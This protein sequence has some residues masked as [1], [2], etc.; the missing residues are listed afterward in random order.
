M[1]KIIDFYLNGFSNLPNW[2]RSIWFI[3]LLKLFIFFFI[4]KIFFFQNKLK[5]E[6]NSDEER[7]SHVIEQLT[8]PQK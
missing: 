1:R 5:K 8:N 2:A 7:A 3:V 6:F 4:F